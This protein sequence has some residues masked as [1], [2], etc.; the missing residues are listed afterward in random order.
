MRWLILPTKWKD[1]RCPKPPTRMGTNIW[2]PWEMLD[3]KQKWHM[4][5]VVL[6]FL[7][8]YFSSDRGTCFPTLPCNI[9]SGSVTLQ[10][11]GLPEKT[12]RETAYPSQ[13][14]WQNVGWL[15]FG[16][17]PTLPFQRNNQGSSLYPRLALAFS[18]ATWG[19]SMVSHVPHQQPYLG[20]HD[21]PQVHPGTLNSKLSSVWFFRPVS[22]GSFAH[23]SDKAADLHTPRG[24]AHKIPK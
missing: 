6:S 14:R 11:D 10:N 16:A 9:F 12:V 23:L 13:G 7:K 5:T 8:L 19:A 4:A 2:K 17:F 3:K 20:G 1:E 21:P 22:K 24:F 18:E 15:A